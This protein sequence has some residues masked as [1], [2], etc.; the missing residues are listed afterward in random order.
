M[1]PVKHVQIGAHNVL[2]QIHVQ[3]VQLEQEETYLFLQIV[4]A[5][6]DTLIM[7]L[8]QITV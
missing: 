2:M 5:K 8:I 7:I 6:M 1:E 4:V 3:Y